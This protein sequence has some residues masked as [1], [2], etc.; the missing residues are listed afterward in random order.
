MDRIGH[1]RRQDVIWKTLLIAAAL[2][3]FASC[4]LVSRHVLPAQPHQWRRDQGPVVPHD[5]FPKDCSLCHEKGTW[6]KIRDDFRFD[7]GKETGVPLFGAHAQAQCLRCHNDRGPVAVFANKGC[8]GCHV[9]YHRGQLGSQC[10][11]CHNECNWIPEGQFALHNRT[12]FPLVGAHTAVACFRCHPGA[13]VGNFIRAPV[14]C[15]ACHQSDLRRARN[16]NHVAQGWTQDCQQCHQPIAWQEALFNHDQFP[17]VGAHRTVACTQCHTHGVF[18]GLSHDCASCHLDDFQSTTNP[19]HVAAGFPRQCEL[20][21]NVVAWRGAQFD[22]TGITGNCVH[23]HL[24]EFNA[25]RRPNHVALGFPT[26]CQACH[27]STVTW[28][29][30]TFNHTGI[31]NGCFRC[32]QADYN[33]ATSPNHAASGF[34]TNC[35]ICH[36]TNQW[37]GAVFNHRFNIRT[38][39]H[40]RFSCSECHRVPS[41]FSI[42]SCT[43]CHSHDQATM[44]NTHSA[45]PGYSWTNAACI[46]CHPR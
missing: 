18:A 29:P 15:E 37:Q 12:R 34:P 38:G 19:N 13:Q 9:D 45:V 39:P 11:Q 14:E 42:V 2:L 3:M 5:S 31:V 40:S 21:H 26:N 28:T 8:V 44:A 43:H 23:C 35:E 36:D 25:T 22:H 6:H 16:P 7:H 27:T 24:P 46:S 33:M 4:G 20:C 1:H 32:H 30:A 17:L 10:Q 41:D